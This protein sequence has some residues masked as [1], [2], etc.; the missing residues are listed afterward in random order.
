MIRSE[1]ECL[2][3]RVP[4]RTPV[5]METK[6]QAAVTVG[7][8]TVGRLSRSRIAHIHKHARTLV[9]SIMLHEDTE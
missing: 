7:K 3:L 6:G 2:C 8:V 9:T 4:R 5:T 1:A